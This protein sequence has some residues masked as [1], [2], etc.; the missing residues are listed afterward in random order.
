MNDISG[1]KKVLVTG[2]SGFLGRYLIKFA[3]SIYQIIAQYRSQQP[4]DY[5]RDVTFPQKD[6]LAPDWW[7]FLDESR[8]DAIIH[9]AAMASIDECELKPEI[10]RQVNFEATARLVDYAAANDVRFIFV[11]SDVIFDGQKGDY[12]ETDMPNPLNAYSRTKVEAENYILSK[13][14]DAVVVRPALFYGLTLNGRPSFTEVILRNLHAG[15][16]VFLFPDQYRTPILVNNLA[17]ALWELVEFDFTGVLHLG[18]A[19]RISRLEMG[20][21]LCQMFELDRHLLVPVTSEKA[22]L[23]AVRPLDCSL[24]ISLART[25]L[26]TPLADCPTGFRIAYH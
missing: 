22:H 26:K 7:E 4:N 8:P 2:S 21:L 11:S 20:E 24:D 19:T 14:C 16:Q 17:D 18:G 25:L 12:A 10:A 13:K 15:K 3:P 5:G 9:A 1:K 6:F 23:V